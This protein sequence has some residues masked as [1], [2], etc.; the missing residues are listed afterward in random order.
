VT[1]Q[2]LGSIGELVAAVATVATLVYLAVQVRANTAAARA[3]ARRATNAAG[4][5]IRVAI[6]QDGE[7]ARI[8]NAGLAD[9]SRLTPEERTRFAFALA[10]FV[11][12]TAGAFHEVTLGVQSL[13]DFSNQRNIIG[14][15]LTTPGGREFW[16]LFGDRYPASF[17]EWVDSEIF[18]KPSSMRDSGLAD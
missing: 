2:D 8:F 7:L 10:D 5:A 6:A 1:V 15:F 3:E 9:P 14:P 11:S 16:K 12:G 18:E 17:K 4:T 13:S